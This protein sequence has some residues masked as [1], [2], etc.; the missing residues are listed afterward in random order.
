LKN[1]YTKEYPSVQVFSYS[2][3][4]RE[5]FSDSEN[6]EMRERINSCKPDVLFVGMTAPNR[7]NGYL[8]TAKQ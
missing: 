1:G 3:P 4:F 6:R 7:K 5:N 2:P 8:P